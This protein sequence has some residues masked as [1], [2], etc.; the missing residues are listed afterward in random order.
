M[1]NEERIAVLEEQLRLA[2][3][4]IVQYGQTIEQLS[5]GKMVVQVAKEG[6]EDKVADI[7]V[8]AKAPI[9]NFVPVEPQRPSR[10]VLG[11][12]GPMN[13]KVH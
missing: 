8:N 7:P 10:L 1:T 5:G 2:K 9:Y 13:G 12:H 4:L 11:A 3:T 6:F